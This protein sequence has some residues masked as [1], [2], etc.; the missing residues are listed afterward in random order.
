MLLPA[1]YYHAI[2]S[3]SHSNVALSSA[4]LLNMYFFVLL[5]LI[6]IRYLLQVCLCLALLSKF[7]ILFAAFFVY[8]QQWTE[9]GQNDTIQSE[10]FNYSNVCK[11]VFI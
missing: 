8:E 5:S 10:P 3:N 6:C 2:H 4:L 1:E 9:Y 11:G 7:M